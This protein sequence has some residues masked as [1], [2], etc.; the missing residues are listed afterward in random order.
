[1][2]E[3]AD[4][5]ARFFQKPDFLRSEFDIRDFKSI[6]RAKFFFRAHF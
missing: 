5:I 2:K 6:G 3:I 1:M 4:R